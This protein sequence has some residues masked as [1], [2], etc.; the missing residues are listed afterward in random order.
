[1]EVVEVG[2]KGDADAASS[3]SMSC[4][5]SPAEPIKGWYL[6]AMACRSA[7]RF[8]TAPSQSKRGELALQVASSQSL[9][10]ALRE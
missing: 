3:W 8:F 7:L 10:A 5:S 9:A 4:A 1:M 6:A 2:E